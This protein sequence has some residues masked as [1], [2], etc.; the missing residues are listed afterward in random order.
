MYVCV[1]TM[2]FPHSLIVQPPPMGCVGEGKG[3]GREGWQRA[4]AEQTHTL[5]HEWRLSDIGS[6]VGALS[7]FLSHSLPRTPPLSPPLL[8]LSLSSFLS[9]SLACMLWKPGSE[10]EEPRVSR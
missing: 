4:P 5:S 10:Q 9:P 7:Y 8:S 3:P 6:L 1:W 2:L